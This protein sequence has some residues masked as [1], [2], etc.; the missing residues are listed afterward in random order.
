M[1]IIL[2]AGE[3][4]PFCKTG[5]LGDV[6]GTLAEKLSGMGHD[7]CLFLPGYK[8]CRGLS[9]RM[10]SVP[11]EILMG[12]GSRRLRVRTAFI[13]KN[14]QLCLTDDPALYDRDGL[15]GVNGQDHADNA[16]RFAV[17]SR[18][19]LEGA[20]ALGFRPDVIH[21]HDWQA[22]LIPAYLKRSC[23]NDSFF[24]RTGSVMTI[25]NMAYQG[26]F[27]REAMSLAG[28]DLKDFTPDAF[29]F[30]GQM[31]FLKA[32][33]VFADR[34]TT[35]SPT[36]AREICGSPQRGFGLEGLLARRSSDLTGILNGLDVD[37]WNPE[38]DERLA[39]KFGADNAESGKSE[40][41]RELRKTC[42]LRGQSR[43]PL[44][45]VISRFDRQKGLDLAMK[46]VEPRLDRCQ[47][48]VLGEGDPRL[49]QTLSD[50]AARHP[51]DVFL[52]RGFDETLAHRIY[53]ACDIFLM[54]SRFE[55]C[56]LGQMIAMRYGALP[57]AG[58]TGGLCDTVFE[59]PSAANCSNGF[60]CASDDAEDLA[61]AM[62]RALDCWET[63]AWKRK[64]SCAMSG[65][66]SWEKSM[67]AYLNVYRSAGEK[68]A[69]KR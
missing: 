13:G 17:F 61:R 64:V 66:Y 22:G 11:I 46:A 57:V 8:D 7:V 68:G 25:H 65:D 19:V 69:I 6:V 9:A 62:D 42:G 44:A 34:L 59:A 4:V 63:P 14:L 53:A 45:A 12:A 5:G 32:G 50:F 56:G 2:A 23:G 3:A 1:K 16:L 60:L 37:F 58:Q 47:L 43:K 15:Y 21:A 67:P 28:F 49:A 40:C 38:T 20:K 41:A 51:G 30:F 52:R 55:P 36:Y 18:A 27:P 10:E 24:A 33:I 35:V 48:A 31:S 39:V 26:N 29:E 54:P